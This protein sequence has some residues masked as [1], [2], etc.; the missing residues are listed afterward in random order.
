MKR[1]EEEFIEVV[2]AKYNVLKLKRKEVI[3]PDI[4][5]KIENANDDE[6][7]EILYDHLKHH[8]TVETLREYCEVAGQ[9]HGYPIMQGLAE[10]MKK[11]LLEGG[12]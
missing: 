4:V 10:K 5:T 11:E 9:A 2:N 1:Y 8:G 3:P 7:T 6:A 12:L